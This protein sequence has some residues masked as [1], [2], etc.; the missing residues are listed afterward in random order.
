M[1]H[2]KIDRSMILQLLQELAQELDASGLRLKIVVIGGAAIAI[3]HNVSRVTDDVDAYYPYA[4]KVNAM[5]AQIGERH[6]LDASWFNN[7][8]QVFAP[9]LNQTP[10]HTPI[11]NVGSIEISIGDPHYILAM[12][13]LASRTRK[14]RDDIVLLCKECGITSAQQ[15]VQ[16]FKEYYP[17][18][19]VTTKAMALLRSV[20]PDR[21]QD[22]RKQPA[23]VKWPK[24]RFECSY[25]MPRANRPCNL[26]QGHRGKHRHLVR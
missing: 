7:K 24:A 4:D 3:A 13:I 20:L 12:K 6:G 8:A 18:E 23:K 10:E 19:P 16:V 11:I 26:P 5:A 22:S 2:Q 9:L 25:W 17:Y 15:A 1:R 14:D 21:P